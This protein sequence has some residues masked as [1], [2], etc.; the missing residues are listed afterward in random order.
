MLSMG[1]GAALGGGGGVKWFLLFD[2]SPA[3][4]VLF[5]LVLGFQFQTEH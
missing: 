4:S 3:V 2:S 1:L 5:S